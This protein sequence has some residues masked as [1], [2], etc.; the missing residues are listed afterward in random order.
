MDSDYTRDHLWLM[1]HSDIPATSEHAKN[2][3]NQFIKLR[4]IKVESC[5][6]ISEEEYG[7]KVLHL[8]IEHAWDCC[9]LDCAR[10]ET[11]GIA[12]AIG[13]DV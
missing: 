5:E 4:G 13:E 3:L 2:V 10:K 7:L 6:E 8:I 1:W 12:D 11:K 9:C